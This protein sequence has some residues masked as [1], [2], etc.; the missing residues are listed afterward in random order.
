MYRYTQ[1][2]SRVLEGYN[3]SRDVLNLPSLNFSETYVGNSDFALFKTDFIRLKN[4]T[5]GYNLTKEALKNLPISGLKV[6]I[7]GE[8]IATWTQWKGF[9]PEQIVGTS[10]AVYPNPRTYS[11]GVN[12][13][14]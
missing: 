10:R 11:L 5:L 2:P 14:L 6:Y 7:V 3:V 1:M 8:N 13:N 12:I 9:D 4:I